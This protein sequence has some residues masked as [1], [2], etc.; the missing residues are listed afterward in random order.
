MSSSISS[1]HIRHQPNAFGVSGAPIPVPLTEFQRVSRPS[2]KIPPPP[3]LPTMVPRQG[4]EVRQFNADD[5]P[6]VH[7]KPRLTPRTP[8]LPTAAELFARI[9]ANDREF[10]QQLSA[11]AGK[12]PDFSRLLEYPDTKTGRTP[13]TTAI[14]SGH[15]DLAVDLM[16][17]GASPSAEDFRGN[18]PVEIVAGSGMPMMLMQ[19]MLWHEKQGAPSARPADQQLQKQLDAIDSETGHTLLTWAIAQRHDALV[20]LLIDSGADVRTNNKHKRD[21]LQEACTSGSVATVCRLLQGWTEPGAELRPQEVV[22]AIGCAVRAD[23]HMVLAQLLSFFRDEYRFRQGGLPS[24]AD[25][26]PL[27]PVTPNPMMQRDA[28]GLFFGTRHASSATM[29][30]LI[31]RTSDNFLLTE[32]ESLLLHLDKIVVWAGKENKT[33]IVE[34]I[35]AHARIPQRF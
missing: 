5:Q 12:Q 16:M 32:N 7:D 8:K 17:L 4:F 33:K 3:P 19:F 2:T 28:Y 27:N 15:L 10:V 31:H 30:V 22:A 13:L 25:E 24:A 1:E 9:R 35:H 6:V 11:F 29:D 34:V 21:A 20:E 23:R 26:N 18:A 14:D